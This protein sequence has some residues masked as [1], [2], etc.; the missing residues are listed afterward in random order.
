MSKYHARAAAT[1]DEHIREAKTA[2]REVLSMS[3]TFVEHLTHALMCPILQL[4]AAVKAMQFC[5][6]D[7]PP[8]TSGR[9]PEK[10]LA[11]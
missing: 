2:R 6:R 8:R 3:G 7:R 4:A 11:T 5:A 10:L 9:L 1:I